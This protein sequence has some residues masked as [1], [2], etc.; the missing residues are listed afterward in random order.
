MCVYDVKEKI[1]ELGRDQK[2][3]EKYIKYIY[4]FGAMSFQ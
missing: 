1:Q 2:R 3:K 4:I